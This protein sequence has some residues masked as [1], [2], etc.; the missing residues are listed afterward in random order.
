MATAWDQAAASFRA[1]LS[2]AIDRDLLKR[3][4]QPAPWMHFAV[5]LRHVL[6][7]AAA[8]WVI[9]RFG[10]HWYAW[11]PASIVIGFQVFGFSVLMHEVVHRTIFRGRREGLYRLLGWLYAVPSGLSAAQFTRWH[12]D[13]HDNLGTDD[14]DPKRAQLSPKRNARWLKALYFTPALFPIYF[15][16]ARRA[17]ASY[18]PELRARIGRE[19]GLA[20]LFH[21]GVAAALWWGLGFEAALKLHLLPVFVVFPVAFALNRLGQH[22]DVVPEDPARWGT[23]LRPSPF[24]WD[25]IYLWSNYHL[26]HH[27]FPKVPFYNLRRLHHALGP[28]FAA[29]KIRR[30]RYSGL[31]YDWLVR[32]QKPHTNWTGA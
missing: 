31:L 24:L 23:V 2:A 7:L 5:L 13:H 19:R 21:L 29:R 6:V 1:E 3:L 4:H 26:E 28:F 32:N 20:T 10:D 9:L 16:A 14:R 22:Y 25:Q 12:L 8:V 17:A 30:R 15:R 27:Y 11:I 18:P